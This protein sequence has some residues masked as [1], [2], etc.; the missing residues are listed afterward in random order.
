MY[1]VWDTNHRFERRDNDR[2]D[3]FRFALRRVFET[4]ITAARHSQSSS[5]GTERSEATKASRRRLDLGLCHLSRS[6]SHSSTTPA[7]APAPASTSTSA[8]F[9]STSTR[10]TCC[11]PISSTCLRTAIHHQ[12]RPSTIHW[13]S[14]NLPL[15]RHGHTPHCLVPLPAPPGPLQLFRRLGAR[16]G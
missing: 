2:T 4:T 5:N 1:R 13:P 9:P 15:R 10:C 14:V 6:L 3:D 16:V 8:D 12:Y 11:T 7:P